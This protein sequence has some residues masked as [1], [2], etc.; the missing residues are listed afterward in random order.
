MGVLART[1]ISALMSYCSVCFHL[2]QWYAWYWRHVGIDLANVDLANVD[3]A[4][5]DLAIVD[6]AQSSRARV[7]GR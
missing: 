3:L 5:V 1:C 6:L 7:T 2:K 4:N